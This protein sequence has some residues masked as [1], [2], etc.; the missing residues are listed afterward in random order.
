MYINKSKLIIRFIHSAP[1]FQEKSHKTRP[2]PRSNF[3]SR[4]SKVILLVESYCLSSNTNAQPHTA[5]DKS[6]HNIPPK[7][8]TITMTFSGCERHRELA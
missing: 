6:T 7:K 1:Q 8:A 5:T 4:T 2:H 3:Q